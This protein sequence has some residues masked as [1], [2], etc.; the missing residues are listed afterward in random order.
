M[1]HGDSLSCEAIV[2]QTPDGGLLMVAQCGGPVEPHPANRVYFW[3]SKDGGATWGEPVKRWPE[4]GRAVYQTEVSVIGNEIRVFLTL[5]DGSFLDWE[6]RVARSVDNGYT[7]EDMGEPPCF[8]KFVFFRG[9][10]ETADHVLIQSYQRYPVTEELNRRL[11][12]EGRKMWHCCQEIPWNENGILRSEDGGKSWQSYPAVRLSHTAGVWHWGEPTV[13]ETEPGHLVML[14]RVNGTG[15][16][17]RSDS[18]DGGRNWSDAVMTDIPNPNNKP[19]LLRLPDGRI[20]LL[21]TPAGI[22]RNK[23]KRHPMGISDRHPLELWISD[24]GMKT[25]GYRR[26]LL[27]FPGGI[28]YPDGFCTPDGRQIHFAIEFNR[29][30]VYYGMHEVEE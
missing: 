19:K 8:T 5:H 11:K 2:R 14:L 20:A 3:H 30:D 23:P 12:A 10:F 16:L 17:W 13:C 27:A 15:F 22:D 1:V 29:H 28:S 26:T 4:D 25:W 9:M 21:N 24:D 18:H 7:W 6:C